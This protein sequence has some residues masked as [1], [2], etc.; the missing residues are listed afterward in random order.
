MKNQ[1][2]VSTKNQRNVSTN[3][4]QKA[5]LIHMLFGAAIIIMMLGIAFSGFCVV[6]N[7][8]FKVINSSIHGSIFGLM[9]AYLGF[10]YFMSVKKL[11]GEVYTTT[12]SFSWDN[13]KRK[14]AN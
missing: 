1:T 8:S 14:K 7:I 13:F 12:E 5:I 3:S 4:R 2:I 9:V 6:N 11:K 10:K